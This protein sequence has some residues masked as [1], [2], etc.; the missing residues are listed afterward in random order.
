MYLIGAA[1][2]ALLLPFV[3]T[4][5]YPRSPQEDVLPAPLRVTGD[6]AAAGGYHAIVAAHTASG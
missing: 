2:R 3:D 6:E 4:A 1:A 5:D